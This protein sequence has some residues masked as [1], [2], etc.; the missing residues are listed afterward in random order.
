[1]QTLASLTTAVLLA[2]ATATAHAADDKKPT[3]QQQRM[4]DCNKEAG[5]KQ[6]KGEERKTFMSRCLKGETAGGGSQQEKMKHCNKEAGD[7]QLKGD[8]RKAFMSECLKK[9]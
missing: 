3:P 9:K 5:D 1:M 4:A 7:K 2:V 8:E 6:L